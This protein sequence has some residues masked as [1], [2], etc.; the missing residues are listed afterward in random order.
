[1]S[2]NSKN[3]AI[4]QI[5]MLEVNYITFEKNAAKKFAPAYLYLWPFS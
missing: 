1:M 3:S 4:T 2:G 5:H